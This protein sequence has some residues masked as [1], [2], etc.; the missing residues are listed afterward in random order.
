VAPRR[1]VGVL[2]SLPG[3]R[4]TIVVIPDAGHALVARAE[5][6]SHELSTAGDRQD[7]V[8]TQ[9]NKIHQ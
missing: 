2:K 7:G 6:L 3:D 9:P 5:A 4:V 8:E 1:F